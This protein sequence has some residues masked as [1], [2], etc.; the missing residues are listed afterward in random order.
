MF[1][2]FFFYCKSSCVVQQMLRQTLA[3]EMKEKGPKVITNTSIKKVTR[4]ADKTLTLTTNEDKEYSGFDCL[5][6]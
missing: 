2:S 4:Q 1:F 5:V 3:E 6:S